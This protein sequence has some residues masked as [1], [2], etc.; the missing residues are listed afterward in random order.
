MT[1]KTANK[2]CISYI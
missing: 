2:L 1:E